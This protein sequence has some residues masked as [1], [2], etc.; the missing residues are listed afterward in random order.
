M[1]KGD[2]SVRYDPDTLRTMIEEGKT[3]KEITK[4]FKISPY[5][6]R[7]HLVMLQNLDKKIYVVK[8][9][10]DYSQA[11]ESKVK[12]EGIVFSKDMLEKTG[13]AP[14]DCFEME[15]EDDRIILKK[16]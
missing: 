5:T 4:A 3:A 13:F 14:G 15:V 9:L 2:Y 16:C 10:F 7:E 6:L 11:E 1:A 8:G 12:K